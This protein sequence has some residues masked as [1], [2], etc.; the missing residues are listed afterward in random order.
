MLYIS[1]SFQKEISILSHTAK[2]L[3]THHYLQNSPG[4]CNKTWVLGYFEGK[5]INYKFFKLETKIR[6]TD[7]LLKQL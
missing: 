3:Q 6:M 5:T 1:T 7:Q 4:M 2:K